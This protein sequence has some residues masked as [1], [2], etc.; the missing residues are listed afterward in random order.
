MA[1][2]YQ[3][4]LRAA[5]YL[6]NGGASDDGFEYF[7]GR[8]ITQGR[9][10]YAGVLGA[11]LGGPGCRPSR[12]PTSRRRAAGWETVQCHGLAARCAQ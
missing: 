5:A 1:D 12:R 3:G 10:V 9:E 7:R 4:D 6:I 2:S 11:A 8:L